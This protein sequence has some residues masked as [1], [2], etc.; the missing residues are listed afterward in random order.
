MV[1]YKEFVSKCNIK[2]VG[3]SGNTVKSYKTTTE[4]KKEVYERLKELSVLQLAVKGAT[5]QFEIEGN[6]QALVNFKEKIV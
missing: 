1:D 3:L 5:F 4:R 2:V 6:L